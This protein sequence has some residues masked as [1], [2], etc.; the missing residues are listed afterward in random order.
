MTQ[1]PDYKPFPIYQPTTNLS[2]VV[3]KL[4]FKGKDLLQVV[5]AIDKFHNFYKMRFCFQK[6]L[7]CNPHFRISAEDAM[8]HSYFSDL[9]IHTKV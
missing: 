1:L 8:L 6:L 7:V 3:P 4:N 2:Q 9:A 5:L